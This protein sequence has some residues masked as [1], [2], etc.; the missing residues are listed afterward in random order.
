M[1]SPGPL[2]RRRKQS[3]KSPSALPDSGSARSGRTRTAHITRK[4]KERRETDT[5]GGVVRVVPVQYDTASGEVRDGFF[6]VAD[7]VFPFLSACD[8]LGITSRQVV[9]PII[10]QF[11]H[12]NEVS[13]QNLSDELCVPRR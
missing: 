5:Y 12:S 3:R 10:V 9:T 6:F 1:S 2:R 13:A 4:G 7:D 11:D 8:I